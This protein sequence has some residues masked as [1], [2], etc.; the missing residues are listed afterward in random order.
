MKKFL[1]I[2]TVILTVSLCAVSCGND[3]VHPDSVTTSPADSISEAS[4]AETETVIQATDYYPQ[5]LDYEGS[6]VLLFGWKGTSGTEFY[7][8]NQD[9]DVVNDAIFERNKTIEE[10]LN[11]K[12]NFTLIPGDNANMKSW[13]ATVTNILLAGDDSIDIIGAYSKSVATLAY[14]RLLTDLNSLDYLCFD[15][16]WWSQSIINETTVDGKLYFA[17]GDISTN[18][19]HSLFGVFFNKT[20]INDFGIENPYDVVRNGKWTYDKAHEMTAD[21]YSDINGDGKKDV[22]DRFGFVTRSVTTDAFLFSG[23]A[24]YTKI[25]SDGIPEIAFDEHGE[26]IQSILDKLVG[27]FKTNE[28]IIVP[29]NLELADLHKIFTESRSPFFMS[30]VMFASD[31]LRYSDIDYGILPVPKSNETVDDYYSATKH[32]YSLYAIPLVAPDP[33]MSAA[34]MECFAVEGHF[35]VSPALFETALKVKYASDED[36]SEMYDIIRRN[37]VYD[38]GRIFG[39]SLSN[40]PQSM[41]RKLI[42]E[43]S[44]NWFSTYENNKEKLGGLFDKLIET[45]TEDI[46]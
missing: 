18:A 26:R 15:K 11:I 42:S 28:W 23:G 25:G 40:I 14:S 32:T 22:S 38:F 45:L 33:D 8:E 20:M 19:I 35:N 5:D 24:R 37:A 46:G 9:G 39:E 6:D 36:A 2:I 34:V 4:E 13:L 31:S 10:E 7:V 27:L 17:S 29:D 30:E 41:F 12:L 44:T 43:G 16:P 21:L 3:K 1:C